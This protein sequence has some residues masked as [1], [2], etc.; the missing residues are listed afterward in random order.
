MIFRDQTVPIPILVRVILGIQSRGY[1]I[2][3]ELRAWGCLRIH[4]SVPYRECCD[5]VGGSGG[6]RSFGADNVKWKPELNQPS[7]VT[8]TSHMEMLN[9]RLDL[10]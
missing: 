5:G 7:I 6:G 4:G 2:R 1:P 8:L 9:R 10:G 3:E